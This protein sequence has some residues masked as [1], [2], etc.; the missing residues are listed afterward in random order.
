MVYQYK[1]N[2][3]LKAPAQVAGEMCAEL[4]R[5]VGLTPKTLLDANRDPAAAL[6][7]EFEWDDAIAAEGYREQQAS[8]IIRH[9]EVVPDMDGEQEPVRAFVNIVSEERS[10]VPI[11]VAI[12]NEDMSAQLFKQALRDMQAFRRKYNALERLQKLMA[13][14]DEIQREAV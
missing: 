9:I 7:N 3:R 6:H 10:Y 12:R 11:G 4:E 13:V 14:M 5:T 8:Y 1:S 2:T